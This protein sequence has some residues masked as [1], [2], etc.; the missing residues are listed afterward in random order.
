MLRSWFRLGRARVLGA[1]VYLHWSVIAVV[2]LLAFMSFQSPLHAAVSIASYL[3]VIIIHELGHA[4]MARRLG[5]EVDAIRIAFLHGCCEYEAPHTE[6]DDVLIAW[7]GVLAQFVVAVPV[8]IIATAFERYDFGYA[9]P[10]VVFLGYFNLLVA[11][12]NLA[13]APGL[14]GK[15][16]W[17]AIPLV[18]QWWSAR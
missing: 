12:V 16:A 11:L 5:Y 4:L 15:T 17:R 7:A 3:G 9:A 13:P 2:G 8:L 1:R 10:A 18:S 14:D 6:L